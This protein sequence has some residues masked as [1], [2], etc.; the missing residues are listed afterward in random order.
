M[1]ARDAIEELYQL[2]RQLDDGVTLLV[3]VMRG[4]IKATTEDNYRLFYDIFCDKQ[5]PIVM[6]VTG[7][8]ELDDM[9]QWWF[10]NKPAFDQYKMSFKAVAC[11][12]ATKGKCRKGVYSYGVEYE[13][14]KLKVEDLIHRHY[15]WVPWKKPTVPWF[16]SIL[17]RLGNVFAQYFGVKPDLQEALHTYG[18]LL[19][20]EAKEKAREM[21]RN[22]VDP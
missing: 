21:E 11:I 20:K 1:A 6:V 2:I 4:R 8:E 3:F 14:S 7:L 22:M 18:G 13:E 15:M 5:V 10:E 16:I 17:A 12:T 19:E 9:G